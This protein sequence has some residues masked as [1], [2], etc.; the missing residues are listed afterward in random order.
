LASSSLDLSS[1]MVEVMIYRAARDRFNQKLHFGR[2]N[3]LGKFFML[4][5][6]NNLHPKNWRK[7]EVDFYLEF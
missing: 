6:W 7:F 2:K 3:L 5:F 1:V 4:T